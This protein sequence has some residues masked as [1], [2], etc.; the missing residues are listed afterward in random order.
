MN[1]GRRAAGEDDVGSCWANS[2]SRSKDS[3]GASCLTRPEIA[4]AIH[5]AAPMATDLYGRA[6][7][8]LSAGAVE[9]LRL[10][11]GSA[12]PTNSVKLSC[13]LTVENTHTWPDI[14]VPQQPFGDRSEYGGLNLE[15]LDFLLRMSKYIG[16]F[17]L[18]IHFR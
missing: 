7:C 11:L 10:L 1:S 6:T 17:F 8:A 18:F 13:D 15:A 4:V 14:H 2:L 5:T 16:R 9:K 3:T 12:V